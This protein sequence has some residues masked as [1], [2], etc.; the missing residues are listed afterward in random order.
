MII[1]TANWAIGD[2][3]LA[4]AMNPALGRLLPAVHRAVARSGVRADGS[5]RPIERLDLVL[6][7]DTFDWLLSSEWL[8]DVK[9][10]HDSVE[11][12]E[13]LARIAHRSF[14]RGRAVL[15]PLSRW[16]RL[17]IDVPAARCGAG[18]AVVAV[19]VTLLSGDRDDGIERVLEGGRHAVS[20]GRRWD[21]GRV[22][23][24]HGHELD[25]TCAPCGPDAGHRRERPPTLAESVTVDLVARF[26]AA[27]PP[28]ERPLV[29]SLAAAGAL[30][31]PAAFAAWSKQRMGVP[32]GRLGDAWRRSVDA[33]WRQA[34][35]SI[36]A[37]E[38]AFDVV[39][40][41]A[42]WYRP[43]PEE[44]GPSCP[45]AAGL[46]G[47]AAAPISGSVGTVFGHLGGAAD[48]PAVGLAGELRAVACRNTRGWPR[49]EMIGGCSA[50]SAVITVR[51]P[52]AIVARG[53]HVIDA[54]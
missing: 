20:A 36:P 5:Y 41:L 32:A 46:V 22:S 16:A 49:W 9:P 28:A 15:L 45:R 27:L 52:A 40:A 4:P 54:A 3:T 24:R 11:R 26:A 8:G 25:P 18:R 53:D 43:A 6:T 19:R 17:G 38:A 31:I 48:S 39:D 42:A 37:V 23:I 34:R 44:G 51:H 10:W 2:G 1:V 7:G 33:W 35:R 29:R 12:I 13:A 47:L 21:D 14:R 50:A 30:G